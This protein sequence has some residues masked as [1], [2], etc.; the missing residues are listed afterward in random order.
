MASAGGGGSPRE[1]RGDGPFFP[2]DASRGPARPATVS[3]A[4]AHRADC[5][6][7]PKGT[8]KKCARKN[9][10]PPQKQ[11]HGKG[12]RRQAKKKEGHN[13]VRLKK[14]PFVVIGSFQKVWG[15]VFLGFVFFCRRIGGGGRPWRASHP[16]KKGASKK[17]R[18]HEHSCRR[19]KVVLQ[20]W[21]QGKRRGGRGGGR[22]ATTQ[23]V[24]QGVKR[25]RADCR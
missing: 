9:Q 2:S 15:F 1:R 25:A 14:Q 21:D 7:A 3:C 18:G 20:I 11:S 4:L 22:K 16:T 10:N 6:L 12:G 24:T 17:K 13:M 23:R 5:A 19:R 8:T